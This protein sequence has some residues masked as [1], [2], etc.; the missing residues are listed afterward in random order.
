MNQPEIRV[1]THG[2]ID[3]V[4][5]LQE[6]AGWGNTRADVDRSLYYEPYGCFVA[7]VGDIDVGVVNSFL[8]GKVGFIGNLIVLPEIRNRGVGEVLMRKAMERLI[9]DGAVTIRLDGVQ[10][11]IP[12]YERLGFKGEYWSLRY[13]GTTSNASYRGTGPMER[14]DLDEVAGLDK[15]FFGLDRVQKLKRIHHDYPDLCFKT[16]KSGEIRGYIMAKPGTKNIRV[17]PWICDP[18]YGEFAEPLLNALASKTESR[19]VWIGLP[20]FNK[21]A[22]NIIEKKGYEQMPS[23][24]RMFYGSCEK[25]EDVLGIF[26]VGAPDKG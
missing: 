6:I 17:G 1:M 23:S 14:E 24:L 2:D 9:S 20:E 25:V 18:K 21:A 22:V 15:C 8:Y 16:P 12:L 10:K 13:S 3:F 4:M 26:G 11:A 19:N 7:S 5:R